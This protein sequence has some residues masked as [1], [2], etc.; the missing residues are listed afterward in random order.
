V[1][2]PARQPA[3]PPSTQQTDLAGRPPDVPSAV[4]LDMTPNGRTLYVQV[5]SG[6]VPVNVVTDRTSPTIR[7]AI[8]AGTG[9]VVVAPDSKTLYVAGTNDDVFAI[10][11]ATEK[12]AKPLPVGEPF[13]LAITPSGKTLYVLD[14]DQT[15]ATWVCPRV[16]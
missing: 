14:F 12:L 11:A 1:A 10:N 7:V 6:L 2:R 15:P 8:D 16:G 4:A 3:S 5:A 13:D 9:S